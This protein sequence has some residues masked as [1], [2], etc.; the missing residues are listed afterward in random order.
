MKC[1][2][3][4]EYDIKQFLLKISDM[5]LEVVFLIDNIKLVA[6]EYLMLF[7]LSLMINN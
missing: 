3:I 1:Y 4:S 6:N 7:I 2:L 5:N